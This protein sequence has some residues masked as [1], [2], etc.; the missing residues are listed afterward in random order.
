MASST[1]VTLRELLLLLLL[2]LLALPGWHA[3]A[4]QRRGGAQTHACEQHASTEKNRLF[5]THSMCVFLCCWPD[6]LL[7]L[8]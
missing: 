5:I 6:A 3:G 1:T 8:D 7:Q 4:C 2:L